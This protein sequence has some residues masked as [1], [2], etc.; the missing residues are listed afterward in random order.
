MPRKRI[1]P[2]TASSHPT[3]HNDFAYLLPYAKVRISR[4]R[5]TDLLDD[6]NQSKI[7]LLL[8]RLRVAEEDLRARLGG[9]IV[10]GTSWF[11]A[12]S[13]KVLVHLTVAHSAIQLGIARCIPDELALPRRALYYMALLQDGVADHPDDPLCRATRAISWELAGPDAAREIRRRGAG[14]L[15]FRFCQLR[16]FT[17][18]AGPEDAQ[19]GANADRASEELMALRKAVYGDIPEWVREHIN[20]SEG[21]GKST[22]FDVIARAIDAEVI[23]T[24]MRRWGTVELPDLPDLLRQGL[25]GELDV[26][27]RAVRDNLVKRARRERKQQAR[28]FLHRGSGTDAVDRSPRTHAAYMSSDDLNPERRMP[29]WQRLERIAADPQLRA[30]GA[31][32]AQGLTQKEIAA[33][34]GIVDRTVRYHLEKLD[35]LTP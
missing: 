27:A 15:G 30:I 29:E 22:R 20:R 11:G 19:K 9:T 24:G 12:L 8:D 16:V 23:E 34:L 1:G 6:S 31:L 28:E 17:W 18:D 7:V 26:V 32:K 2:P 21:S 33:Q 35:D 25:D 5:L 4:E 13:S 3:D 10:R 14:H